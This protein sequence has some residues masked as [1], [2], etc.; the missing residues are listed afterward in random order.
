[1]AGLPAQ[2]RHA[3]ISSSMALMTHAFTRQAKPMRITIVRASQQVTLRPNISCVGA[4]DVGT[5]RTPIAPHAHALPI[6]AETVPITILRAIPQR[7]GESLGGAIIPLPTICALAF[8]RTVRTTPEGTHTVTA[9]LIDTIRFATHWALPSQ[10]TLALWCL[11]VAVWPTIMGANCF[12]AN[13]Y[14]GLSW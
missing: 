4:D 8:T 3:T 2:N 7:F 10:V 13:V 12:L 6:E 1:M 14:S 5:I 11:A 9:T